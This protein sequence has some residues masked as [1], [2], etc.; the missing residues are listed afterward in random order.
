MYGTLATLIVLVHFAFILF[1]MFG[2]LLMLRWRWAPWLH[3]PAAAWG[4]FIEFTGRICPLT[5]LENRLRRLAGGGDYVGDFI[6][7]YLVRIIYPTGLTQEMQ[8]ALGAAAILLNF[9]IYVWVVRRL[10]SGDR[11]AD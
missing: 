11:E 5:P 6:D 1:V 2:G 8:V 4:A 10:R 3:L 7:H 9:A